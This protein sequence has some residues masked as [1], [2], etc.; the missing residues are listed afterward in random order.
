MAILIGKSENM[1]HI[2][3]LVIDGR[4][5]LKVIYYN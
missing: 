3:D 4:I 2:P 5:I 1:S